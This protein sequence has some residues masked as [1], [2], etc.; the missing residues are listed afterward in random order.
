M[1]SRKKL[2]EKGFQ[3]YQIEEI[4]LAEKNGV[5]EDLIH[6]WLENVDLDNYQMIQVR[7]GLE[8]GLDVSLYY[9]IDMSAKAMEHIRLQLL[10]E[11]QKK[12]AEEKKKQKEQKKIEKKEIRHGRLEGIRSFFTIVLII[13]LIATLGSI[14]YLFRD[15]IKKGLEVIELELTTNSIELPYGAKFDANDYVKKATDGEEIIQIWP[16]FVADE[17]G[18]FDLQYVITNNVKAVKRHLKVKVVDNECP[19]IKLSETDIT[20]I[21]NVDDFNGFSYI[22]SV[23]D[24]YDPSPKVEIGQIDWQKRNQ[25]IEYTVT[26]SEGNVATAVLNVEIKNKPTAYVPP[27]NNTPE[28]ADDTSASASSG[29]NG[30][31]SS[32]SSSSSGGGTSWSESWTVDYT[33]YQPSNGQTDVTYT[34]NDTGESYTVSDS[35]VGPYESDEDLW[36]EIDNLGN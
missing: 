16:S 33:D 7:K 9:R 24:N 19:V 29:S 13:L 34:N 11:K 18:D 10:E 17:L 1:I 6:Q 22:E 21:R 12:E 3:N 36:N 28:T 15:T 2:E 27:V 14:A 32:N 25:K 30:S 20:L 8:D 4:A 23:T 31:S 5:D 26:D 35:D